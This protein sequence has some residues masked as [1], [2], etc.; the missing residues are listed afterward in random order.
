MH[1]FARPEGGCQVCAGLTC[2]AA[3]GFSNTCNSESLWGS[4]HYF[5]IPKLCDL[6]LSSVPYMCPGMLV[7]PASSGLPAPGRA[8]QSCHAVAAAGAAYNIL[9]CTLTQMLPH[10]IVLQS[11]QL[12]GTLSQ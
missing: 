3:V 11:P 10:L 1:E 8:V 12:K 5:C 4:R 9:F 7:T 6:S 2:A